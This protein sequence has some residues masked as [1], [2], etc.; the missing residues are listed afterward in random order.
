MST[1]KLTNGHSNSNNNNNN[2]QFKRFK[3]NNNSSNDFPKNNLPNSGQNANGRS[4]SIDEQRHQL[5][6]Y[7][8][9]KQLLNKI[10]SSKTLIVIGETGSGKTTQIP[11]MI[12][13]SIKV[14]V[15][16]I[17][18]TQPR[19]VAAITIAKRV[20]LEQKCCI[21]DTV[22]Y[23]V[24]FE[25]VT[26]PKTK[27]KY[28]TD[29]SLLREALSD[30]FLRK[31]RV[32]I[33]DEAHERTINTDVLFG[34]VKEAQRLRMEKGLL[35][36]KIIIM[37]ATMDV[38]H[39]SK[40]FNNCEPIYLAGRTY[41][42]KVLH[43]A[44]TQSDYLNACLVTLFQIH[45]TI[46]VNHDVLI[47]LTGQD[48]IENLASQIRCIVKVSN[49][50][51]GPMIRVFPLYAQLNQNKQLEVFQPS[52]NNYRKV[53]LS[54]NIAETSLTIKG[55]KYV[56]DSGMVKRKMYDSVTGMDTLKVTRISQDQAWQRT[57]RAG[58]ESEGFCYRT[59]T[60][61]EYR[62]MPAVSVPEILR[63][64]ITATVLQL[65]ALGINC[66]K[67]DFLDKPSDK[68]IENAQKQLYELGAIT[69]P[70]GDELTEVGWNMS[71]FPLDPRFSKML[72]SSIEF[73]CLDEMLSIVSILSGETIFY[74]SDD[75]D[76]RVEALKAHAKF[77]S[78]HGDHLTV[79]NVYNEFK[80]AE[81]H[82]TFCH[83]NYLHYRNLEYARD[84][85]RQLSVI[86]ERLQLKMS[87]CGNDYDQVR[88]CLLTGL[89]NNVA[90]MQQDHNFVS[91]TGRLKT[92]IHPSSVLNNK[93]NLKFVL[94]TELVQTSM[95]FMRIVSSI[96]P[97]WIEEVV[98]NCG[99]SNRLSIFNQKVNEN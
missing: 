78:I 80:H 13:E 4:L 10:A 16:I 74:Q 24:R 15:G 17:A 75:P 84:V 69:K 70:N 48:E 89:Y 38:D 81:R 96:E 1:R 62:M 60:M 88:K 20:A 92:K 32:I 98:P 95:N 73:G 41:P 99:L 21:G 5:P 77:E 58:R 56:I 66:R 26:S 39:F 49:E 33:L 72:L 43:T 31:Y 61:N 7:K 87:S 85:R 79:L 45:K 12:H 50:L 54:T 42:V 18:V 65:L 83:E 2:D 55:I 40:Y 11:Q 86:C 52:T 91:V 93:A 9:R 71:K 57:G 68:D 29:G 28:M 35:P 3:S 67:F 19:R 30:K 46:P 36:L 90:E 14:N 27:I 6:V 63:S 64:N 37:S 51:G 22:G 94:F 34:I 47:F 97:E 53:I 59:Y 8:V 44:E 25:D 76:K 82:R 23:T